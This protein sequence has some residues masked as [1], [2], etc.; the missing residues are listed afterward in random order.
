[1]RYNYAKYTNSIL[2][3]LNI[4]PSFFLRI[5]IVPWDLSEKVKETLNI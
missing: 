4:S 1:M 5:V 2:D 3:F